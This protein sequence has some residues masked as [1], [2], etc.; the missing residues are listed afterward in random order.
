[1]CCGLVP[2]DDLSTLWTSAD[3]VITRL[4]TQICI[5]DLRTEQLQ[6]G[7]DYE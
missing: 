3:Y 4:R 2:R 7:L 5:V 6:S 1:M